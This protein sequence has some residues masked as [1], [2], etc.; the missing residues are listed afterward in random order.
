MKILVT[1][2]E[3]Q[4]GSE[5]ITRGRQLGLQMLAASRAELDITSKPAVDTFMYRHRPDLVINGAAYTAVDRAEEEQDRAMAINSQ[6]A[7][8]LAGACH[9]QNIPLLHISTDYV[10]DGNQEA[11]YTEDDTPSPQGIYGKSKLAGDEA[12]AR[13][14]EQHII[15]RVAWVFGAS[16]NNFVRTM[17]RLAESHKELRVVAD[18]HGSPTWA[19]DIGATLLAIA[20]RYGRGEAIPWGTYNYT[21]IPA[22]TWHAFAQTIFAEAVQLGMLTSPPNVIP[23]T[24]AEYPTP[25][26]RP[27]NSVLNCRKIEK[28]LGISQ[29]DWRIGLNN[30]LQNWKE[31]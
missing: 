10:F 13:T 3:G 21:G 7:A 12:V 5:L 2:A 22:T 16:G 30:T 25:T 14:L 17:L 4:V 11:P 19:G 20:Q 26:R 28:Q 8:H 24:T 31:L 27:Q 6:G 23:I 29:P 15:L 9:K 18:Q 1:G